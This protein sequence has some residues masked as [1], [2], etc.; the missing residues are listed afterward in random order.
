MGT[1]YSLGCKQCCY[2]REFKLG[3]GRDYFPLANLLR[4]NIV[5]SKEHVAELREIIDHYHILEH[6]YSHKIY[7]CQ[8]CNGL[9]EQLHIEIHTA[10]NRNYKTDHRCPK[11]NISLALLAGIHQVLCRPCPDCGQQTI[12]MERVID[13]D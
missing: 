7:A 10:E 3:I 12:E 5:Q 13:W 4:L 1:G 2:N 11:C 8:Q 6:D 9:F